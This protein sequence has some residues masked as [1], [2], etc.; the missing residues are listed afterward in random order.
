MTPSS[1][2]SGATPVEYRPSRARARSAAP[3]TSSSRSRL[4][5]ELDQR[6]RGLQVAG[7]HRERPLLAKLPR[8]QR[9][10]R[11]GIA[12]VARQVIAADALDCDDGA[13]REQRGRARDRRAAGHVGLAGAPQREPRA[14]VGAGD[15]LRVKA[16]VERIV[17]FAPAGRAQ[18]P[19]AHRRPRAVVREREHDAEARPAVRAIDVRI[20]GAPVG[21]IEE[22][23]AG[24]RRTA[25]GRARCASSAPPP[26]AL[27]RI[28][29]RRVRL[30]RHRLDARA[31]R[32][33][34]P[35]ADRAP[36]RRRTRRAPRAPPRRARS[37][38]RPRSAPSP[39]TPQ[40][41]AAR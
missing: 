3:P 9:F 8:A 22:F 24:T 25:R 5:I 28:Y 36:G 7:H 2:F 23:G 41:A 13:V 20:A 39:R 4:G 10:D 29:E 31:T 32:R 26:C 40:R 1:S 15:R 19:F 30:A 27:S 6:A 16:A 11:G 33:G 38:R 37:R 14:A 12:R 17:V 35:A 21:G 18:R 34:R